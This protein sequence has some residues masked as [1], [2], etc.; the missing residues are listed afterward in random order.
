[1]RHHRHYQRGGSTR[2][3][4]PVEATSSSASPRASLRP[5]R[6]VQFVLVGSTHHPRL[7][8]RR[9]RHQVPRNHFGK[10][11]AKGGDFDPEP[12]TCST[13]SSRASRYT[14]AL[15]II[16][17][18]AQTR[19]P[20]R[21]TRKRRRSVGTASAVPGRPASTSKN[22]DLTEQIHTLSQEVNTLTEEVPIR[23]RVGRL[24]QPEAD[25][26]VLLHPGEQAT[27]FRRYLRPA[28]RALQ[29]TAARTAGPTRGRFPGSFPDR[30]ARTA[31]R[32][33]IDERGRR[34]CRGFVARRSDRHFP[35]EA[36]LFE[37]CTAHWAA[38][39]PP[40]DLESWSAIGSPD[41]RLGV[42]LGELYAFYRR[43]QPML[44]NVLRDETTMPL[45]REHL[46]ALRGYFAAARDALMAGRRLRAASAAIHRLRSATRSPFPPGDPW[47]TT[48]VSTTEAAA[49]MRALVAAAS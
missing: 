43:T 45:V 4:L 17:Q 9:R 2:P 30:I 36:A 23:P 3:P 11:L 1:M 28:T 27:H 13:S 33:D 29:E 6:T 5:W 44:E 20:T 19:G 34:T 24:L 15:V 47:S 31:S 18:K 40:P 7:G 46:A 14:G 10:A 16:A 26:R 38:A 42:A 21:R 8:V 49:L 35:D 32:V 48:R 39:N 41:E 37:A 12:C 22:T 25:L